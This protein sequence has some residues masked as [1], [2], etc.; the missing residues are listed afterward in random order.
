MNL[1]RIVARDENGV[2]AHLEFYETAEDREQRRQ[3]LEDEGH[4][5][6]A[7]AGSLEGFNFVP[8]E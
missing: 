1:Y 7:E 6:E 4:T 8:E 3:Q 5:V 2:V